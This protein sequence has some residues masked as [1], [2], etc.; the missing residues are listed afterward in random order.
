[1]GAA[2]ALWRDTYRILISLMI[3][4]GCHVVIYWF[5]EGY[6][7]SDVNGAVGAEAAGVSDKSSVGAS[8]PVLSPYGLGTNY[9]YSLLGPGS[10]LLGPR[11]LLL[12]PGSLLLGPGSLLLGP[13]FRC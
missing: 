11:S 10:L 5:V 13:G 3:V 1:M 7:K 12:G 4:E 8:Y 6:A 2:A 9:S